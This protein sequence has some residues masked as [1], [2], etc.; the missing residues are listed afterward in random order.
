M[1]ICGI[2]DIHGNLLVNIPQCDVLCI[3]G[4]VV[5][6]NIQRNIEASRHW[7]KTKFIK[8]IENLSCKKV[9]VVPGN[10]DFSLEYE[11]RHDW[12]T[13]KQHM[14]DLSKGKLV[15][16]IDELY[17]YEGIKFYGT[18]WINFIEFQEGRWAFDSEHPYEKIP[19]CDILLTHDS[20]F[21]NV[22]LDDHSY[23]K[24]K[25]HLYGHWHDG[26]SNV[27]LGRYNCSRLSNSY[28]FKKNYEFIILD[29]VTETEK[30]Q[31]EQAFLAKIIASAEVLEG[32][33]INVRNDI[34]KFLEGFKMAPKLPQDKED[35][36]IW[37][38]S[39]DVP[40]SAL[41]ND[42]EE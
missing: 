3:C 9:I 18:P 31:V 24:C 13:Y 6:L 16:L 8:W 42:M 12:E 11:Y 7:W 10:H 26:L 1:K 41:I 21:Y 4:D 22:K 30:K 29:I 23:G 35:E 37:D 15:F 2:S 38:T 33:G 32:Q 25:Y 17:K 36:V 40:E 20:P 19:Q 39:A 34:V 27:N 5:A 28:S 14:N